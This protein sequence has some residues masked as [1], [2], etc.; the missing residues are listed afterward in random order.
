MPRGPPVSDRSAFSPNSQCAS[1]APCRPLAPTIGNPG[2]PAPDSATHAFPIGR[3]PCPVRAC[4]FWG[5]PATHVRIH[6]RV[7]VLPPPCPIAACRTH[8]LLAWNPNRHYPY[9]SLYRASCLSCAVR[10]WWPSW[11]PPRSCALHYPPPPHAHLPPGCVCLLKSLPYL[12]SI[13]CRH[14]LSPVRL[15]SLVPSITA[16]SPQW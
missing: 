3:H 15:L 5:T 16:V 13:C 2:P 4:S 6:P 12:L 9:S 7:P 8:A 11:H 10:H 14:L 1:H